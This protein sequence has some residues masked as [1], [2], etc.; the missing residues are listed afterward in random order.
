MGNRVLKISCNDWK[1]ASHDKREL[2]AY[3]ELGEETA[4]VAKGNISDKGRIETI[5]GFKV[6]RMTTRPLGNNVPNFLNRFSSLFLWARFVKKLHVDVITAHDIDALLIAWMSTWNLSGH[7][8][9]LI[10]DSHEFEIERNVKRNKLQKYAI[11]ILERFLIKK[12]IF[13]IMVNDN[14]AEEVCR[15][16]KLKHKPVVVRNVAEKWD[17]QESECKKIRCEFERQLN[18]KKENP[19]IMLMYHGLLM[20]GR[21]IETLIKL[22]SSRDDMVAVILGNAHQQEYYDSL[23]RLAKQLG[24]KERILF[25]DAVPIEELWKYVGAVD[26]GMIL[27]PAICKNFLYSLPNKFFENI[28]SETPIIC[29]S[30]PAMKT[31]MDLY[32]IGITCDPNNLKDIEQ[33]V[34]HMKNNRAFYLSCKKNLKVAKEELCWNSEKEILKEAYKNYIL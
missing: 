2:S 3:R 18:I 26:V 31:L 29:P 9:Q 14:I 16:H 24:G 8:P 10:Y 22:V 34:D 17:I 6:F 28:Q 4:V 32:Q 7:R 5:D 23:I 27:A 13:S 19:P 20:A 30:Y 33:A 11:K 1:N 15:I 25:H 21:G 12:C